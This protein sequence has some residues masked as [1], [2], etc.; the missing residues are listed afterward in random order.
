MKEAQA[1]SSG[2]HILVVAAWRH[3]SIERDCDALYNDGVV[4]VFGPG[5]H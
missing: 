4:G 3:S 1:G 5:T 2:L